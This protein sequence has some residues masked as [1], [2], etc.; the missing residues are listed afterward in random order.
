MKQPDFLKEMNVTGLQ[1]VVSRGG[2][3]AVVS[4]DDDCLKI[5]CVK[6]R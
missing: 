6:A 3:I 1:K 5:V 2:L 4:C